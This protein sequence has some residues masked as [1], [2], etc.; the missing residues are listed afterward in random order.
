[1][2]LDTR[3]I[4]HKLY[5]CQAWYILMLEDCQVGSLKPYFKGSW[6]SPSHL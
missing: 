5:M 4:L 3:Y 6:W 1:M 2:V